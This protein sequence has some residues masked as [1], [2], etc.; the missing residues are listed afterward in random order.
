M[1]CIQRKVSFM[2][3]NIY[4]LHLPIK[5]TIS[6]GNFLSN[7]E[8]SKRKKL[9]AEFSSL[10]ADLEKNFEMHRLSEEDLSIHIAH[11]NAI[12]KGHFTYDDPYT[13]NRVMTRLRH[14]LRGSCCGNACR[15]VRILFN[16]NIIKFLFNTFDGLLK[17]YFM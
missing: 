4:C 6:S 14:F 7:D 11:K 5:V 3:M 13:Q 2:F 15:H 12:D 9:R 1:N 16:N 10:E 8:S 17:M